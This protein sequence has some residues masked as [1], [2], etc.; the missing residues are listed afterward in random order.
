MKHFYKIITL[1]VITG[2]LL[3]SCSE[4]RID[5]I[6]E[7][8][9][10][11]KVVKAKSFEPIANVKV[12]ISPTNNTAFT[13]STGNFT[14]FD[15]PAGDYSGQAEKDG[16]LA[17]IEAVT[18]TADNAT[19]L[20]F[21]LE[22]DTALNKPPSAPV[23]DSPVDNATG[24]PIS[25]PL[26]WFSAEDV[27]EDDE[28]EY[29]I[30]VKNDYDDSVIKVE[31][32]IDTTYTLTNLRYGV[33]YFWQIAVSDGINDD[34]LTAVHKFQVNQFPENRFFYVKKDSIY[35]NTIIYSNNQEGTSEIA[36]TT[37]NQNS[38][39]PRAN[40]ASG[41]IGFLR[42]VNTESHL[43]TMFPDGSNVKKVTSAV[44]VAGFNQNEIDFA[45][46][47]NGDRFLYPNFDKLYV[48]N[49]DG[50]GLQQIYQT[51]DGSFIT[52]VDWSFD[53]SFIALK[54][55]DVNG[56][57]V[58]IFTIDMN[59]NVLKNILSGEVG[60]AGGLNISVDGQQLLYTRD[61]SGF[62]NVSNRQLDSHI[63]IYNLSTDN[64]I[65]LSEDNKELGTNDLDVRFSPNEAYVIFVNTSNDGISQKDVYIQK[66]TESGERVLLFSN[67]LMPDWE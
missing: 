19:N 49:K 9:I 66:I 21:E 37:N 46:S 28:L 52:E 45:W 13:D 30:I 40:Q 29:T 5:P 38:W 63:F 41:L 50:S 42:T 43:F 33:K 54:T 24:L 11:G 14:I 60:A 4:D 6:G 2:V 56:Y 3:T 61:I 34:V 8:T 32:I 7:G 64:V 35:H 55:N 58:K 36:L 39:R 20:I 44:P 67:S 27:D 51:T 26:T 17:K 1:F 47:A 12:S 62:E 10:T 65:D 48:I 22:D 53:E 31:S 25:V 15:V 18:V 23:I 16:Y 57:G 59:G